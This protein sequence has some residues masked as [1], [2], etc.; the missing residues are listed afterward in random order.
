MRS[1]GI[2][3]L[4]ASPWEQNGLDGT[5]GPVFA[6]IPGPIIAAIYCILFAYVA[7]YFEAAHKELILLYS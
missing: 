6:S 2:P 1:H 3:A 4:S 7:I 5:F